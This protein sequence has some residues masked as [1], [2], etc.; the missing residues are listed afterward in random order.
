LRGG[1][2]K[3]AGGAPGNGAK[4]NTWDHIVATEEVKRRRGCTM[5]PIDILNIYR[6]RYIDPLDD[7]KKRFADELSFI[8]KDRDSEDKRRARAITCR[9]KHDLLEAVKKE[10]ELEARRDIFKPK[11]KTEPEPEPEVKVTAEEPLII[12]PIII[13]RRKKKRIPIW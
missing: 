7:V 13:V 9:I 5:H 4:D 10:K 8:E 11:A 6:A 1:Y 3:G 2:R 12:R